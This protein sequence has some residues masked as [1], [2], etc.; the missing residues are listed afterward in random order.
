MNGIYAIKN[1]INGK[2]YIGQTGNLTN[3]FYRHKYK[4]NKKQHTCSHLQNSWNM[5]GEE[6]F[7]FKI[8]ESDILDEMLTKREQH[9]IETFKTNNKKFGYNTR[10]ASDSNRG[11]KYSP[12]IIEK[13]RQAH[14]GIR[15]TPEAKK[16][17]SES[18]KGIKFSEEHI[19]N[20]SISHKGKPNINKG[21][22]QPG[23]VP[24]K[25]FIKGHT[26][27]NRGIPQSPEAKEKNRLGHLGKHANK[28][29]KKGPMSQEQ[30]DKIRI[31]V[32]KAI[33]AGHVKGKKKTLDK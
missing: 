28:G 33:K 22:K 30:K 1:K 19:K 29:Q 6:A 10:I 13:N 14:L 7:E 25:P 27:W 9:F 20:L 3:R 16:R 24:L 15:H 23:F 11:I 2:M 18:R 12:E 31:S 32:L 8:L 26:P 4:L 17:I 5:Y 21:K